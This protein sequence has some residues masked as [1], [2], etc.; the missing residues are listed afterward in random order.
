M[1]VAEVVEVGSQTRDVDIRPP[2][3]VKIGAN[4]FQV[5]E[6]VQPFEKR[7]L[8]LHALDRRQIKPYLDHLLKELPTG[9]PVDLF[10]TALNGTALEQQHVH[11]IRKVRVGFDQLEEKAQL[12]PS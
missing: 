4:S 9:R 11:K 7:A 5:K 2:H 10:E 6:S 3:L 8:Q 1:H 12:V